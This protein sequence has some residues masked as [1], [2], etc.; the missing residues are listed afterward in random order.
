[1]P[2]EPKMISS[3]WGN[4]IVPYV[5]GGGG[6]GGQNGGNKAWAWSTAPQI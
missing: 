4:S 2:N 5:E 6:G 3:G 1:M